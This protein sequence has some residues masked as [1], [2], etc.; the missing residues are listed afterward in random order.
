[1]NVIGDLSDVYMNAIRNFS[2]RKMNGTS[3]GDPVDTRIGR[4]DT[5]LDNS[6]VIDIVRG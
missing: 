6:C 3:P 5:R 4:V 2:M 1:M